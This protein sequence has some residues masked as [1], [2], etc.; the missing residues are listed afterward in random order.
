[1]LAAVTAFLQA[2]AAALTAYA[3]HIEFEIKYKPVELYQNYVAQIEK[4]ESEIYALR[5][6]GGANANSRA[7]SLRLRVEQLNAQLK[8][9]S[10]L[11][12]N[13]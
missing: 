5:A 11:I 2:L 10:G 6:A 4:I 1:M 9:I 8:H 3:K 13:D 12:P 7:D